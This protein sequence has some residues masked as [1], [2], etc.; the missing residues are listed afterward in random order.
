MPTPNEEVIGHTDAT[1]AF[2]I[3]G[4]IVTVMGK[5]WRCVSVSYEEVG[6]EVPELRVRFRQV[7]P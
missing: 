7:D 1:M 3:V 5:R 6:V 2:P 4:E